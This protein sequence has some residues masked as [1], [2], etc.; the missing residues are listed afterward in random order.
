MCAAGPAKGQ[1]VLPRG[2]QGP[3]WA[4]R[5][6][7]GGIGIFATK[8]YV[9]FTQSRRNVHFIAGVALFGR[10]GPARQVMAGFEVQWGHV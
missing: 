2:P 4:F 1:G 10:I 9:D 5:G 3:K 8:L 7:I 6:G